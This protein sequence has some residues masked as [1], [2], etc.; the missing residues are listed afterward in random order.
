MAT[1]AT[2]ETLVADIKHAENAIKTL[3]EFALKAL[4]SGDVA[5]FHEYERQADMAKRNI[6]FYRLVLRALTN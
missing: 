6:D 4:A 3:N 1:N 2:P 5:S